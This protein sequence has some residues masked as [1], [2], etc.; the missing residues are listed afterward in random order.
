MGWVKP[1]V[2]FRW[3]DPDAEKIFTGLTLLI[4]GLREQNDGL[5]ALARA[6]DAV[7]KEVSRIGPPSPVPALLAEIIARLERIEAHLR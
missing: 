7:F 6:V 1:M 5:V 3:R 4:E 2:E